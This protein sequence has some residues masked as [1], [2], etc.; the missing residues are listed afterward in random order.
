MRLEIGEVEIGSW[1]Q[2]LNSTHTLVSPTPTTLEGY[3]LVLESSMS[4]SFVSEY[5]AVSGIGIYGNPLVQSKI[6][7]KVKFTKQLFLSPV[8][9]FHI[10]IPFTAVS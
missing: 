3:L 1:I 9:L 5:I 7:E 4:V 2:L 10:L 6:C 8:V